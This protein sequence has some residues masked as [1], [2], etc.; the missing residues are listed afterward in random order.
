[1]T[2]RTDRGAPTPQPQGS[3]A[4]PVLSL[5]RLWIVEDMEHGHF[6]TL[7]DLR[8]CLADARAAVARLQAA[9]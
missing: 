3:G 7:A 4:D 2:E 1:M 5:C 6:R 8:E 9:N